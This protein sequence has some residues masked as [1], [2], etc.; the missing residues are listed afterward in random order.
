MSK[1]EASAL[2]SSKLTTSN[3]DQTRQEKAALVFDLLQF[4][5]VHV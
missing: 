2:E 3:W 5:Y 4:A 1:L